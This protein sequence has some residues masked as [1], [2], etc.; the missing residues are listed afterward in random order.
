MTNFQYLLQIFMWHMTNLFYLS[1]PGIIHSPA[2]FVA[3]SIMGIYL[4]L[5]LYV[6]VQVKSICLL[7][8]L[9]LFFSK[10]I[11]KSNLWG[12]L[13]VKR[14]HTNN[15]KSRKRKKYWE[16]LLFLSPHSEYF[17]RD[18]T[19]LCLENFPVPDS[20]VLIFSPKVK[21]WVVE[22][23]LTISVQMSRLGL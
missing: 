13:H 1:H 4:Y 10:P 16:T 19:Y 12:N 20:I 18:D 7:K 21:V 17:F 2:A 9:S 11:W 22:V 6:S 3:G 15:Q 5:V 23:T 8:L 14:S